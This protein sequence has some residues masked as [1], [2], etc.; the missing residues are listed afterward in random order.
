[1]GLGLTR[2][3]M[4]D[5]LIAEEGCQVVLLREVLPIL[6]SQWTQ[7]GRH[8]ISL[9]EISFDELKR[10]NVQ[11]QKIWDTVASL[12]MDAVVASGFSLSRKRAAELIVSGRV[13]CNHRLCEKT[14]GSVKAGDIIS[15]R[16]L[17]KFVL[18][19]CDRKSKKGRTIVGIE[20]YT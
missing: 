14:D 3:K 10:P 6:E 17:G 8:P 18:T 7:V 9:R 5:I 11:V 13:F 12:R 2:E 1:M 15:A 16:G 19:E 20:R 4:G